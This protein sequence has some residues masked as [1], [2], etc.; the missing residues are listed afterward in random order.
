[1]PLIIHELLI[2]VA[3]NVWFIIGIFI[4]SYPVLGNILRAK[5]I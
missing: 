4:I 1:M 2:I 5:Y 3:I